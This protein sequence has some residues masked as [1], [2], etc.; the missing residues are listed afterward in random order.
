[1][2]RRCYCSAV[3][4]SL[5]TLAPLHTLFRLDVDVAVPAIALQPTPLAQLRMTVKELSTQAL[6]DFTRRGFLV[7]RGALP[8]AAIDMLYRDIRLAFRFRSGDSLYI[9]RNRME[10]VYSLKVINAWLQVPTVADLIFHGD[11]PLGRLAAQ[12][13]NA[14]TVGALLE[15][16][17]ERVGCGCSRRALAQRHS[18]AAPR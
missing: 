17:H 18:R 1:M 8:R 13:L 9:S 14:S 7:V 10:S 16:R 12:L 5:I 11:T 4:S 2:G 3:A 6:A 15:Q